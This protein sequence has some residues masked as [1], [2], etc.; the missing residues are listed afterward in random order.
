MTYQIFNPEETKLIKLIEEKKE[1]RVHTKQDRIACAW[2][3]GDRTRHYFIWKK[4]GTPFGE[5][6][7]DEFGWGFPT[8]REQ[9]MIDEGWGQ[10]PFGLEEI[11]GDTNV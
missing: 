6:E 2:D 11:L 4:E 7:F 9:K 8:E 3:L 5:L 10:V 1:L